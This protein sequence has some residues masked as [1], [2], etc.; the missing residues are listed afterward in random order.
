MLMDPSRIDADVHLVGELCRG[1]PNAAGALWQRFAPMVFR[2]LRR[3]VGPGPDIEDL[4]QEVFIC[5]FTKIRSLR[6][7]RALRAFIISVVVLTARHECRKRDTRRRWVRQDAVGPDD[8][9]EPSVADRHEREALRRFYA[10][11]DRLAVRHRVVFAL[12]FVE[13]MCLA[14]IAAALNTSV[15]TIKRVLVRAT[16]RMTML[17]ARD[18]VLAA[19]E[20][21]PR[22]IERLQA[23]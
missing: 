22:I 8:A 11:M 18:P 17:V 14:E 1:E 9:S 16:R 23:A 3:I 19:Y 4:V 13:G 12:R 7:P 2:R 10:L 20:L 5:V 21:R 6:D 15:A